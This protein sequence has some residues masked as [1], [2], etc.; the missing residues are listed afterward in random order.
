M[1]KYHVRT[2]DEVVVISGKWK[3]EHGKVLAILPAKNRVVLELA[4]LSAEKQRQVG[5]RT[6][7]KRPDRPQGGL[8]DRSISVHISNVGKRRDAAA[9]TSA[10]AVASAAPPPPPKP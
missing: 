6:L 10:P 7:R 8:V 9:A 1:A 2:G 3:G 5:R 4:G